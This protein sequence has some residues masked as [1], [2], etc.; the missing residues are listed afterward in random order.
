MIGELAD[1]VIAAVAFP[2]GLFRRESGDGEARRHEPVLL[3]MVGLKL[4]EKDAAERHRVL[5]LFLR[6]GG[7]AEGRED[8]NKH[9]RTFHSSPHKMHCFGRS[10]RQKVNSLS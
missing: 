3:V 8:G 10:I 9:D 6:E 4:L 5:L 1:R 2:G 7:W